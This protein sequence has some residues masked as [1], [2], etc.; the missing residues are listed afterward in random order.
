MDLFSWW[1]S[2]GAAYNRNIKNCHAL[3]YGN[4]YEV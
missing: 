1:F 2:D 3:A 4:L